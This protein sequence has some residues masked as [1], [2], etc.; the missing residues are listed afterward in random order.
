MPRITQRDIAKKL[1]ISQD[2]VSTALRGA[3]GVSEDTRS[4]VL[5][6]ARKL[7]YRPNTAAR[8][9]RTGRFDAAA[10]LLQVHQNYLPTYLLSGVARGLAKHDMNMV[11]TEMP[12]EAMVSEGHVPKLLREL[13]VDG[14]L[15]DYIPPHD[16]KTQ[17]LLERHRIPAI[18]IND[19]RGSDCAHPDDFDAGLRMT[20]EFIRAGH[21]R[22]AFGWVRST[23]ARGRRSHYSGH[24]RHA[25]YIQAMQEAGLSPRETYVTPGGRNGTDDDTRVVEFREMWTDPQRPSALV[26]CG[27]TEAAPAAVAAVAEGLT[28]QRGVV[29]GCFHETLRSEIGLPMII[30]Q[31]PHEASGATAAEMLIEKIND[32]ETPLAPRALPYMH[33]TPGLEPT[34]PSE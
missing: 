25:G 34:T 19:K 4:R 11:V 29:I 21:R 2:A 32:P 10:L 28:L 16:Q 20:R 33:Q 17:A 22:I 12:A 6:T 15:I 24:D 13:A 27:M 26:A 7:G 14:L 18:W 23:P 9:A 30:W 3:K 31:I 5:M 1:G 8:A